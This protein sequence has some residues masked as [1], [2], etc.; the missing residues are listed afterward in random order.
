RWRPVRRAPPRRPAG[1]T[2]PPGTVRTPTQTQSPCAGGR[3]AGWESSGR[4]RGDF[5][6]VAG[7]PVRRWV[8]H[9]YTACHATTATSSQTSSTP[10]LGGGYGGIRGERARQAPAEQPV[11][12]LVDD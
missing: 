8:S 7:L 3:L 11:P 1:R 10:G 12:G 4:P 5:C 9:T 2:T 6:Y